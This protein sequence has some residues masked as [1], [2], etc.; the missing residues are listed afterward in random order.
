MAKLITLNY[1]QIYSTYYYGD[2]FSIEYNETINSNSYR[3]LEDYKCY[4]Y[5]DMC[6][7]GSDYLVA[8]K[9]NAKSF[10]EALMNTSKLMKE[11]G[12]DPDLDY[13]DVA[14]L[15]R[16]MLDANLGEEL[17]E[18]FKTNLRFYIEMATKLI[19][20]TYRREVK[21]AEDLLT[22]KACYSSGNSV[23]FFGNKNML[24]LI[25]KPEEFKKRI[26]EYSYKKNLNGVLEYL[27]IPADEVAAK[28]LKLKKA[29]LK[30]QIKKTE[31]LLKKQKAQLAALEEDEI[32]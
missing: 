1:I 4:I 21:E 16:L 31:A 7:D 9:D 17:Y 13:K 27:G 26:I 29:S 14:D 24:D 23:C 28:K 15:A 18:N 8:F 25:Q 32:N 3:Y 30:A 6:D 2:D 11:K 19:P 10:G 22:H 12:L 5:D 20:G